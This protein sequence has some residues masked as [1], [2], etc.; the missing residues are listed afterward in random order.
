MVANDILFELCLFALVFSCDDKILM[1]IGGNFSFFG[2]A[3]ELKEK[4]PLSNLKYF[5]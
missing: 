3:G 2:N 5:E 1:L 4:I